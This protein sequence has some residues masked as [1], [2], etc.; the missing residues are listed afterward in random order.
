PVVSS[1]K[2][3][4]ICLGICSA[5]FAHA[6]FVGCAQSQLQ[7]VHDLPRDVLL[8][9]QQVVHRAIVLLSPYLGVVA[10]VYELDADVQPVTSLFDA[11][12]EYCANVKLAARVLWTDLAALES[13][14]RVSRGDLQ[15]RRLRQVVDQTL[16]D[17]VGEI[18]RILIAALVYKR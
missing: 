7:L 10:H 13:E 15:P 17:P 8:R 4:L 1:S 14:G 5:L 3:E 18:F 11:A 12:G 6:S 9:G 16:G 2:I